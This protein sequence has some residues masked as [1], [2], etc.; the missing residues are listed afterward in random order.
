LKVPSS[1]RSRHRGIVE[2]ES[3]LEHF[4]GEIGGASDGKA[5]D[6]E[7]RGGKCFVHFRKGWTNHWPEWSKFLGGFCKTPGAETSARIVVAV[8]FGK[9]V[10]FPRAHESFRAT[11]VRWRR[12]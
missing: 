2:F 10:T 3:G 5:E 12:P 6:A 4:G 1:V 9:G 11:G 8:H 7:Q